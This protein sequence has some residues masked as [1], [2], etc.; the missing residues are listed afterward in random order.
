MRAGAREFLTQPIS[1]STI[2]EALVRASVRRPAARP[3]KKAAGKLMV[4]TGAKG[5]SGVTTVATN[6]AIA[7]ARESG[8]ST[9]LID[10][11]LPL[12]D[13]ALDLGIT[14][15]Y[16]T[17]NALQE[18]PSTGFQFPLQTIDQT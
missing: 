5:G 16:S 13:A 12:G 4:F 8:R 18:Q 11:D 7:V 17:A 1:P 10:L 15:Q 6:F 3:P 9:L 14:A 2:A